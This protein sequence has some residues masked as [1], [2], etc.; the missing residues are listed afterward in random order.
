MKTARQER[1]KMG[2]MHTFHLEGSCPTHN[3][4]TAIGAISNRTQVLVRR[5]ASGDTLKGFVKQV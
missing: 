1:H 5:K 3:L 2:D 4:Q